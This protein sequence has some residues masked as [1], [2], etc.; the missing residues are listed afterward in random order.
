MNYRS[1]SVTSFSIIK[2]AVVDDKFRDY[3]FTVSHLKVSTRLNT[4]LP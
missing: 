3:N 1:S 4:W 2:V